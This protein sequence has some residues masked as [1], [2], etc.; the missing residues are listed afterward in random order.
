MAQILS[1]PF[2]EYNEML[3]LIVFDCDGVMFDSREANRIYYNDLLDSFGRPTMSEDELQHVHSH[4][5]ADSVAHVFRHYPD[6]DLEAVHRHRQQSSYTPYLAHMIIEPDLIGFLELVRDRYHLAISTNRT[7]TMDPLLEAYGL[8]S[9]F[10]KIV[11]ALDVANPKPAPDA[12][13][14]IFQH[15][16][17]S[18]KET[19]YIGDSEVD[20]L[21]TQAAS[22]EL[23]AFKNPAL[24]APYHVT[25]FMEI[26]ELPPFAAV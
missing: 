3:K 21:H 12:L 13:F 24:K 20:R 15:F 16:D 10:E 6:Q 18:A 26:L 4:N 5:V 23:I 17:C 14:T 19:I 9:Y 22:V 2:S 25:S 1:S 8:S 7:T 11:T